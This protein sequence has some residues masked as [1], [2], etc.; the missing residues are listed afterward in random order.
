MT[1]VLLGSGLVALVGG[2]DLLVRGAST[3]ALRLGLPPLIVGL[4]VIA[5]GTSMPELVVSLG[6]ALAAHGDLAVGNVVGSNIANIGLILGSSALIRPLR[7]EVVLVRRD[8]PVMIL[9]TGIL[10]VVAV[11]RSIGRIEGGLFL[12]GLIAYTGLTLRSARR[13]APREIASLAEALPTASMPT[14]LART[15]L[16]TG[17]GLVLLLVGG[18]AFVDGAVRGARAL[19]ISEA[20]IGL[21]IVAVGTSLP[22]LAT[23]CIAAARGHVDIAV[24]NAV[25]SNLFNILGVLGTTAAVRPLTGL[26]IAPVDLAVMLVLSLL[27]LPLAWSG[28]RLDRREGALLLVLYVGYIVWLRCA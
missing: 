17:L 3:L 28:K 10:V 7:A 11:D 24:G 4:T 13:A 23:S 5:W 22:E 25:G 2:A 16:L 6:G 26:A 14:G 8:I 19:G 15:L 1:F 21:T 12:V 20:V 27:L 9:V 18:R